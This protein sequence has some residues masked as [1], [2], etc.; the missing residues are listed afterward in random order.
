MNK[1]SFEQ[2]YM[3]QLPGLYRLAQ[4]I[5]TRRKLTRHKKGRS[6]STGRLFSQKSSSFF[7]R[8]SR[9]PAQPP[10]RP[11]TI[12]DRLDTLSLT[13]IPSQICWPR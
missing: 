9:K 11:P 13:V 2:L 8:F 1:V 4:G 6:V 10:T 7:R 5:L 3:E 12:W